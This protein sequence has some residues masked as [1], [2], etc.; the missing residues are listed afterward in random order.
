M[1]EA[2]IPVWH[3][4]PDLRYSAIPGFLLNLAAK[5]LISTR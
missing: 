3:D 4:L 2:V 5:S 1:S